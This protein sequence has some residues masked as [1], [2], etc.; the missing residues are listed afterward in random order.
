MVLNESHRMAVKVFKTT[1]TSYATP[2]SILEILPYFGY[3]M[4]YCEFRNS[5]ISPF[6]AQYT[7][8]QLEH[9]QGCQKWGARGRLGGSKGAEFAP[10]P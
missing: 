4:I 1:L 8:F 5:S 7:V 3:K 10:P 9:N 6:P 2:F